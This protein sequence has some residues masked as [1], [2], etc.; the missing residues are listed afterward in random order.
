MAQIITVFD[1]SH[2]IIAGLWGQRLAQQCGFSE[3]NCVAIGTA[4]LEV[5]RNIVRY[6]GQGTVS[7][8]PIH[9]DIGIGLR[10]SA[11]DNGPGILDLTAALQDGYT[12]GRGLGCGLPGA[13]RL[14]DQFDI[15]SQPG[16]GTSITMTK[17]RS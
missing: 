11:I 15:E 16:I 13:K 14:M 3:A 2:A 9:D 4:I 5:A 10:V 17:W 12:T 1:D 7:I 6:A 8:I